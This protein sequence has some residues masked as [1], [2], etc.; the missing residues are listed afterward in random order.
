MSAAAVARQFTRANLRLRR[1]LSSIVPLV[2]EN[3]LLFGGMAA[4]TYGC[5]MIYHP[6][7]PI[8]GGLLATRVAFMIEAERQNPSR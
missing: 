8:V 4:V 7:G 1:A 2:A 5:W 6:L 3:V